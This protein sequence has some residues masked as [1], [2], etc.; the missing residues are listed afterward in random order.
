MALKTER[1]RER[2]AAT[3]VVDVEISQFAFEVFFVLEH[4]IISNIPV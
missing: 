3:Q 2:E 4:Y 1:E